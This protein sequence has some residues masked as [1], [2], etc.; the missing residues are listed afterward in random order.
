M[1]VTM[2]TVL[3][4]DDYPAMRQLLR[5][6]LERYSDIQVVGEAGTGEEGVAQITTLKPAVVIIDLQLP[7]MTG[8]E[9]TALMKQERPSTTIIGLTAGATDAAKMAMREAGAA[10]VLS[11]SDLLDTLYPAIIEESMLSKIMSHLP[12]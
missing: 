3:L 9:A 1:L 10:T 2:I 6:I 11:K 5:D 8:L 4:V 7:T 12:S